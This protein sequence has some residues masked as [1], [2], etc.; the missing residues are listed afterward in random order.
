[1]RAVEGGGGREKVKAI[2]KIEIRKYEK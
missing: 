1:L 2:E